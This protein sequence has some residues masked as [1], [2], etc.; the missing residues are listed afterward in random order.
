MV[1]L[2][3]YKLA[4]NYINDIMKH[5]NIIEFNN[6][7]LRTFNNLYLLSQIYI[8]E[9]ASNKVLNIIMNDRNVLSISTDKDY[10]NIRV[11]YNNKYK[12]NSAIINKNNDNTLY[13]MLETYNQNDFTLVDKNIITKT[14][15]MYCNDNLYHYNKTVINTIS[16]ND[17]INTD[18]ID[19][20]VNIINKIAIKKE[21]SIDND[22]FEK[23]SICNN[24]NQ[25]LDIDK[26]IF[27]YINK[28]EYENNLKLKK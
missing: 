19:I 23:Y 18:Y 26:N 28:E 5:V 21:T 15:K 1:Y 12:H 6:Y 2:F 13:T 3:N 17:R 11:I 24:Y 16:F 20:D 27:I 7:I 22:F 4:V 25:K 9:K 14:I 10:N 8:E